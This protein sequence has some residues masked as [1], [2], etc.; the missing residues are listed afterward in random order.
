MLFMAMSLLGG[1]IMSLFGFKAVVVTGMA[2]LFGVSITSLGYYF[3]FA[4]I[5]LVNSFII[6]AR[7]NKNAVNIK[8]D[9]FLNKHNVNGAKKK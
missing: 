5:G 1:W 7:G 6:K 2:Q 9:E 8:L 3:I 4:M